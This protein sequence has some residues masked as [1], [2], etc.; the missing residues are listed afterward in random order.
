VSAGRVAAVTGGLTGIGLASAKALREAG[1]RLAVGSRRA[2]GPVAEAARAALGA[3]AHIAPLDVAD[4]ASVA[5]FFAGVEAALGPVDILVNAAGIYAEG[6]LDED[7]DAA[8]RAQIDVNLTGPYLTTR[9][10]FAGMKARGWGRIVNIASTAAGVGSDGYAGYCASKAGVV[11]L[12]RVTAIEGAPHGITCVSLSPTWVNTP[13]MDAASVRFG[14]D[15]AAAYKEGLKA[16]NPQGRHVP[17]GEIAAVV[18]FCC[19]DAAPA[20]TNE[21][22]QI[23][24]GALW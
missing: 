2:D 8:W 18:A 23:N 12:S 15:E 7:S 10:V 11:A 1:A 5:A 16:S 20:L 6:R 19:S 13:M 24:A 22:I 21:D 17:P 4:P 14:G 9:A 3:E